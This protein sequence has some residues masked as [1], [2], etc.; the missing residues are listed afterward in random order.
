MLAK[1]LTTI[2]VTTRPPSRQKI[3]AG[4]PKM[5]ARPVPKISFWKANQPVRLIVKAIPTR[6]EPISPKPVHRDS[7]EVDSPS[8]TPAMPVKIVT[9][10]SSTEPTRMASI[11]SQKRIPM[12][13][14]AARK[15]WARAESW[16]SRCMHTETQE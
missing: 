11:A 1:P 2:Q 13:M 7:T 9:I 4:A 10:S 16:P 6:A 8:F 15:N 14:L 12:P 3:Q 5:L